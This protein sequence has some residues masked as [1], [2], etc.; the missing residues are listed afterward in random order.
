MKKTF[1]DLTNSDKC[2]IVN[3]R[4]QGLTFKQIGGYFG[5]TSGTVYYWYKKIINPEPKKQRVKQRGAPR[6]SRTDTAPFVQNPNP[7]TMLTRM[8]ICRYYD[9]DVTRYGL[10]H[11]QALKD[12][13][14]ELG[15][16]KAYI[17]SV[18]REEHG[19]GALSENAKKIYLSV[20]NSIR[21]A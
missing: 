21:F 20:M 19:K 17:S 9:E 15:R 6:M 18:L 12:I 8:L 10:N 13:S 4:N 5:A 11:Q 2:K 14:L 3:M 7:P 1:A 16:T